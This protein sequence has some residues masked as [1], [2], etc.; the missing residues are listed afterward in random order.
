MSVNC[1]CCECG[2]LYEYDESKSKCG[3][4]CD[5]SCGC[6]CADLDEFHEIHDEIT[7]V[8][9]LECDKWFETSRSTWREERGKYSAFCS[10]EC[11]MKNLHKTQECVETVCLGCGIDCVVCCTPEYFQKN[12]SE[13]YYCP[14][15]LPTLNGPS[16]HY[17]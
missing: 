11:E 12:W 1:F 3:R 5:C 16:V 6:N 17:K 8:T 7:E 2:S 9:C 13:G 15:T 10:D 4:I 14:C